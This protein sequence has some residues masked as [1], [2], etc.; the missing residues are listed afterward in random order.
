M[1]RLRP[2]DTMSARE[3]QGVRMALPIDQP[4][5]HL[6]YADQQAATLGVG[7]RG[8]AATSVK[9][10]EDGRALESTAARHREEV[11]AVGPGDASDPLGE[12]EDDRGGGAVDLVTQGRRR[13]AQARDD[14]AELHGRAIDVETVEVEHRDFV[15]DDGGNGHDHLHSRPA[16]GRPLAT[17]GRTEAG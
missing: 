15:G 16:S 10:I 2:S 4:R 7:P 17:R 14:R 9:Q 8:Q 13:H 3:L 12:R 5:K 1:V 11:R 6:D